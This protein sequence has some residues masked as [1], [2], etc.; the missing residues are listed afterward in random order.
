VERFFKAGGNGLV[1]PSCGNSLHALRHEPLKYVV[2]AL[3]NS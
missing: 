3:E 1:F 2:A